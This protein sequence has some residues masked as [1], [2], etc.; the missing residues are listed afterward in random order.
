ME[1][2]NLFCKQRAKEFWLKEGD[3]KS[4]FFHNVVKQR[5]R[6]TKVTG[7]MLANGTWAT[8]RQNMGQTNLEYYSNLFQAGA[9]RDIPEEMGNVTR[10]TESHNR[11]LLRPICQE[12]VRS[13]I[14]GMLPMKSPGSD[15]MNPTF[16]S[17]TLWAPSPRGETSH[18]GSSRPIALCNVVYKFFSKV[19]ASRLKE[20]LGSLIGENQSAF[21]PGK[22]IVDN[23]IVA[24]ETQHFLK[25]KCYG[26]EGFVTLKLDMSKAYDTVNWFFL[27][28]IML[29]RGFEERWVNIIMQCV[30]NVSNYVK[31]DGDYLGPI[32]PGRGLRQGDPLSPYRLFL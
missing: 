21:I 16:F 22:S 26:K 14:F 12:E 17:G 2:E 20:I 10:V 6:K 30:S 25:R 27:K 4:R 32:H 9:K 23:I 18:Y 3:I 24:F 19:L 1:K 29:R 15:A 28:D 7:I 8:Q 13:A 11:R 31:F 5:R